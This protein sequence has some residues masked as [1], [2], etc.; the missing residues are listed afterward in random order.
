MRNSE[1]GKMGRTGQKTSSVILTVKG[2]INL[3][4][5][6]KEDMY[7]THILTLDLSTYFCRNIN[8][9]SVLKTIE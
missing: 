7:L 4:R 9:L 2:M 8:L 6:C 3:G 1:A 5:Y